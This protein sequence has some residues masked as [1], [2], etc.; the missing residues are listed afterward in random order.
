MLNNPN[1]PL[2]I[3]ITRSNWLNLCFSLIQETASLSGFSSPRCKFSL[4]LSLCFNPH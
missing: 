4:S 3:S 1:N 2:S